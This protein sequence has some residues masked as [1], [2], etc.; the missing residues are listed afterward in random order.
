MTS[1]ATEVSFTVD[2]GV[3]LT[4]HKAPLTLSMH[5]ANGTPL[6]AEASP[7]SWNA[8][9]T[10]QT[11]ASNSVEAIF[12]GGMQNGAFA[13]K[14]QRILITTSNNW[15]D[16]GD[17]NAV[18]FYVSSAGYAVYRNTWAPGAYDFTSESVTVTT[19]KVAHT[20]PI[21]ASGRRII[22]T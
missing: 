12:G 20:F 8:N 21:V 10:A 6:W 2:G 15:A 4:V 7:L 19:H 3:T 1:A 14:G 11:L 9:G 13:H 18:P 22:L 5:G 16:G 17:P